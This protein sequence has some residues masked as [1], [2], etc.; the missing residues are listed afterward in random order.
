MEEE[1]DKNFICSDERTKYTCLHRPV[2]RDGPV[3]TVRSCFEKRNISLIDIDL[4]VNGTQ[5]DYLLDFFFH[6]KRYLYVH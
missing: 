4:K 1:S 5:D 3:P 2:Y 6:V